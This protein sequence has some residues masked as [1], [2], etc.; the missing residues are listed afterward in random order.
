MCAR[1]RYA[2]PH[3]ASATSAANPRAPIR[4]A[5]AH[6]R[7]KAASV[8]IH[9]QAKSPVTPPSAQTFQISA[10]KSHAELTSGSP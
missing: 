10:R 9:L 7:P 2:S 5:A 8:V 1:L 4:R 6:I 3:A